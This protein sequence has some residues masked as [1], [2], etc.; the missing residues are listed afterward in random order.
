VGN[1]VNAGSP[2][3]RHHRPGR[4][5]S[6]HRR[7][8]PPAPSD[9]RHHRHHRPAQPDSPHH[10]PGP[11]APSD[12]RHHRHH[13]P[14]QPDSPHRRRGRDPLR[15]RCYG[16]RRRRVSWLPPAGRST[17]AGSAPARSCLR[18]VPGADRH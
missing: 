1:W 7:P 8:G 16:C 6:P 13:R 4:P 12:Q 5:D 17:R 3:R 11:P 9:Q 10:Q 18:V 15:A 2:H 14:A